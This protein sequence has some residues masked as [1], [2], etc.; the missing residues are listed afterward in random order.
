MNRLD[1]A[2]DGISTGFPWKLLSYV[3]AYFGDVVVRESQRYST[4]K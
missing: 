4:I 3:S 2:Y 1:N